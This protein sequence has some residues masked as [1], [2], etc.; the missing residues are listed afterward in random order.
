VIIVSMPCFTLSLLLVM[1]KSDSCTLSLTH[2]NW[3]LV[4]TLSLSR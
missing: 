1:R 3:R 4:C 2:L